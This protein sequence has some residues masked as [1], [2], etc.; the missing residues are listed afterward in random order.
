MRIPVEL[1]DGIDRSARAAGGAAL[2][3][4]RGSVLAI[5]GAL[6][7]LPVLLLIPIL[8]FFLLKD[9]T[10]VRRAIVTAL[11]IQDY[12]V[13]PRL[14]GVGIHLHPL[15]VIVAVLSGAEL[16]GVAGMFLAVPA[17]AIASVLYRHGWE[18]RADEAVG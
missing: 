10:A 4:A 16:G 2:E 14:I 13:Y 3:S 7:Y 15:A 17:V 6:S 18:C 1:R 9:A 11:L 12:V 8:A 5:A